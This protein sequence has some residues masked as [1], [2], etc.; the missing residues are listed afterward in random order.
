[1]TMIAPAPL[2]VTGGVDTHGDV[3]VAAALDSATGRLL[4]TASFPTTPVGYDALT[5]WL[6]GHGTTE[7]LGVESTGS[8]GAGLARHLAAAGVEVVEVDRADRKAR[9]FAGKT[10]TVDAEAAARA[11]LA[12]VAT[13]I[14]KARDG[15][16]E[17]IRA[18]EVVHHSAVKDRTR[19]INQFKALVVTAPEQ[20]RARFRGQSWRNQL[21]RARRLSDRHDDAVIGATRLALRELARRIDAS[22]IR[23]PG[24]RTAFVLWRH[25]SPRHCWASMA[26]A[27][28]S[29]RSCSPASGTTTTGSA[30]KP[31]SPSSPARTRSPCLR[32][33]PAPRSCAA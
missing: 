31:R 26:S 32:A 20:V 5:G 21:A 8:Y 2:R 28:S 12:G 23:P 14:P 22:T 6:A 18:L 29:P 10:D 24:S 25:K 13:A 33:R 19:A 30:P 1:M 4:G 3:H 9:R 11:V 7:R 15:L 17:A 27:R 16:V